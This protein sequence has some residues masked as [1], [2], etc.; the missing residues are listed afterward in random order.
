MD[1]PPVPHRPVTT[2]HARGAAHAESGTTTMRAVDRALSVLCAFS[3]ET[4]S[5]GVTA[6]SV[7]LGLTK[8]TVHRLLQALVKRG[9]VTRD[10]T[11]NDYTLGFRVLALAQAV[12][13]EATLRQIC[14]APMHWLRS[15]TEETVSLYVIAGDVRMCL[16][17]LESP[18]VLRMA[19]GV[20]RC[21]PLHRGAASKALI[22]DGSA[23]GDAWGRATGAL[24][25]DEREWLIKEVD[26][27]RTRGFAVSRGETVPGSA[28]IAA[29]V[30]GP[31][32]SVLAALSVGGPLTRFTDG[33]IAKHSAAL[34]E[35]VGRIQR[36]LQAAPALPLA[37]AR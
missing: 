6:L 1:V 27:V 5:L 33:A 12:Q 29:P 10:A 21:F 24:S 30:R 23:G 19:A 31:G 2:H 4:P 14:Q 26:Q 7:R 35:A 32:G 9:L 25:A 11:H 18:Q 37:A 22:V 13:G 15:E 17:E 28:S 3:R 34:L 8:S 36:D 16:D 20:G